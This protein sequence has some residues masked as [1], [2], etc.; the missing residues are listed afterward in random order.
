M[1]LIVAYNAL[2]LG[3]DMFVRHICET[4]K[5][6]RFIM[7]CRKEFSEPYLGVENLLILNYKEQLALYKEFVDL[8]VLIGGSLFMQPNDSTQIA[9]KFTFNTKYRMFDDIPFIIIGC[10]FGPYDNKLHYHL[11]ENWFS[12]LDSISFRDRYSYE[13]F[14]HLNNV[15]FYPDVLFDYCYPKDI[16]K[17]HSIG[18]SCIFNDGRIG[19]PEYDEEQYIDFLLKITDYYLKQGYKVKLFSFCNKQ[20]DH[21]TALN[22]KSIINNKNVKLIEYHG[23]IEQFLRSLL[24]VDFM[25]ATR[26]HSLVI[27]M[28][29]QIPV[30]PIIYNVKTKNLLDDIGYQGN[31]CYISDCEKA[32]QNHINENK[33]VLLNEIDTIKTN[34]KKHFLTFEKLIKETNYE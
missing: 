29:N 12:K 25:I 17:D 19:L 11:H 15:S 27:S 3:D 22:I 16:I 28:A 32:D 4:Y 18:V 2:N 9:D 14:K 23:S 33:H 6:V 1:V 5:K 8:Q 24:S 20:R 10:N 26:F 31:F 21:I 13:L 34:S 7:V 30:F